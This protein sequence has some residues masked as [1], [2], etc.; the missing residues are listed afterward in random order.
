VWGAVRCRHGDPLGWSWVVAVARVLPDRRFAVTGA[1]LGAC[2]VDHFTVG[3]A[4]TIPGRNVHRPGIGCPFDLLSAARSRGVVV[5]PE[6]ACRV[7][8]VYPVNV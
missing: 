4:S 1:R 6:G 3:Q 5:L 8:A 2:A 7:S